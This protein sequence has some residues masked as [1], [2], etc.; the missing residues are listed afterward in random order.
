MRSFFRLLSFLVV[1]ILTDSGIVGAVYE[2][3]CPGR[4]AF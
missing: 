4:L 3:L 2:A 1:S